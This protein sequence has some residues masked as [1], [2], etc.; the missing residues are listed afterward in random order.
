MDINK[1]SPLTEASYYVLLALAKPLHGYGIIK[2]VEEMSAGR[3]VL[4]AGTLYGAI[5][6]L[7]K[8]DLIELVGEESVSRKRKLYTMTANGKQLINYEIKR[9]QEMIKNGLKEMEDL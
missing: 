2:K 4:A 9:L 8:N 1:F 7:L 6:T 3:V 5:S